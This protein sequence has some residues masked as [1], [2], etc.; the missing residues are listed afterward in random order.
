MGYGFFE[1]FFSFEK[2]I[3]LSRCNQYPKN[4][5]VALSFLALYINKAGKVMVMV[6]DGLE[7]CL[8][9]RRKGRESEGGEVSKKKRRG[10]FFLKGQKKLGAKSSLASVASKVLLPVPR[11]RRSRR[12]GGARRGIGGAALFCPLPRQLLFLNF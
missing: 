12:G 4:K 6:N 5:I 8:V 11:L 7:D 1:K 3:F 10:F 2:N 9:R